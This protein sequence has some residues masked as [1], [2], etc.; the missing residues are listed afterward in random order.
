MCALGSRLLK[1]FQ[2]GHN[3]VSLRADDLRRLAMWIDCNAIFYGVNPPH[4]QA[5]QLRGQV[6]AMPQIQ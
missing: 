6:V 1:M 5:K 3:D 4:D 2:K